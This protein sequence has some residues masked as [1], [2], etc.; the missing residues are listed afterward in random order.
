MADCWSFGIGKAG[1]ETAVRG[2]RRHDGLDLGNLAFRRGGDQFMR[3]VAHRFTHP[4]QPVG[5]R[6]AAELV[7]LDRFARCAVAPQQVHV[8]DRD[9]QP[10][11]LLV[12]QAKAIMRRATG[13]DS[14]QPLAQSNPVFG[15]NDQLA[16]SD[17]GYLRQFVRYRLVRC[18][19]R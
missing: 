13:I 14:L 8:F 9:K 12:D 4:L 18:R 19:S 11:A 6:I 15:M 2:G 16:G 3:R 17:G 10:V 7:Q 1:A 5:P